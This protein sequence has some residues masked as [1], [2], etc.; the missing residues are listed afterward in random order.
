MINVL[1]VPCVSFCIIINISF[2][3][4][5][6]T[7][8]NNSDDELIYSFKKPQPRTPQVIIFP[9]TN[10]RT[11]RCQ[12]SFP[13]WI[14]KSQFTILNHKNTANL[15]CYTAA[16]YAF[17]LSRTHGSIQRCLA[18]FCASVQ[19][20]HFVP[21]FRCDTSLSAQSMLFHPRDCD[22]RLLIR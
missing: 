11:V 20:D 6:N 5:I 1:G 7:R 13:V 9:D 15:P 3:L 16:H 2:G 22:R 19:Q 4:C 10:R 8:D 14:H 21:W 18:L 17:N 12:K